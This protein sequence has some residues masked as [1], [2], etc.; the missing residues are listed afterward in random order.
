MSSI[1]PTDGRRPDNPRSSSSPSPLAG[2][3][4]DTY[5]T[6]AVPAG[7]DVE[8]VSTYLHAS[9]T[10]RTAL[11]VLTRW[12]RGP[13]PD[14]DMPDID[15]SAR[16]LRA[17]VIAAVERERFAS[18]MRA[19]RFGRSGSGLHA[20]YL[21][22]SLA[23]V[24]LAFIVGWKAS[25]AGRHDAMTRASTYAT[26]NGQRA[27]ITLSD[28]TIVV[29]GVASRLDVPADYPLGNRA[30]R[31]SGAALFTVAHR[32][33]SPVTVA[34]GNATARV[35]GTSFVVRHYPTDT[36]TTVAVRD[37]KVG[38]RS[39]VVTAAQQA[40]V[41]RAGMV[42]VQSVDSSQFS[43]VSGVLT[44][45]GGLLPDVIPDLDRWYDVDIRLGDPS[46]RTRRLTGEYATGSLADVAL[47]LEM[48]FNAR[49]VRDGRV[50]TLYPK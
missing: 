46:F 24:I 23:M 16:A 29:L 42:H 12:I 44:L 22:A 20:R 26:R 7:S 5:F 17:K 27:T 40:V 30:L 33:G 1:P 36:V 35:L 13:V 41:G 19:A 11:A 4:L 9:A 14:R 48:T 37:G 21:A 47:L 6:T 34:A 39:V 15:A 25:R 2:D 49:V 31:L 3:A 50:L 38:V 32:D 43:F 28:G 10:R 8:Q 18:R 45:N